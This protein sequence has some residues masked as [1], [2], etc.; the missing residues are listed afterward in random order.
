MNRTGLIWVVLGIVAILILIFA[1]NRPVT[2]EAMENTATTT[3]AVVDREAAR[4][5]AATDLAAL[6]VRAEAGESYD[7]LSTE[8]AEVRADLAAAY[9]NAEGAAAEEWAEI[10]ADFDA[11]EASA[12]EGTGN[13]LEVFANLISRLSADVRV[14]T[15]AE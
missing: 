4:A 13:L 1:L 10:R 12:R 5:E 2:E 6:R 14:E 11:F 3:A 7:D 9:D 8:Y 15:S